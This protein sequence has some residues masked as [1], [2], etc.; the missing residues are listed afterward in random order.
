MIKRKT[1]LTRKKEIDRQA[2]PAVRH[3][4]RKAGR[5]LSRHAERKKKSKTSDRKGETNRQTG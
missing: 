5:Q 2:E 3:I 4:D 1:M